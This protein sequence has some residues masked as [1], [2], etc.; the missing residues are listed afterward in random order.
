MFSYKILPLALL[1]SLP[2][3]AM[4]GT[5]VPSAA[6]ESTLLASNNLNAALEEAQGLQKQI[7][8]LQAKKKIAV[9]NKKTFTEQ[10]EA[11]YKAKCDEICSLD[12]LKLEAAK[13]EKEAERAKIAALEELDLEYEKTKENLE[14]QLHDEE[15]K[16][17]KAKSVK[18]KEHDTIIAALAKVKLKRE[19]EIKAAS[20]KR[21]ELYKQ[22]TQARATDEQPK[23]GWFSL[24]GL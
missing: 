16:H 7:D 24:F 21:D 22:I 10:L 15:I 18:E 6:L 11:K 17:G 3:V 14:K 8:D 2:A 9:S 12:S 19:E 20:A 5:V 23:T 13:K 1:I 4:E